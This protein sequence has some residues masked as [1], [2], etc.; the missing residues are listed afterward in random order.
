M[1]K[2]LK[3]DFHKKNLEKSLKN[4]ALLEKQSVL[5]FFRKGPN[6]SVKDLLINDLLDN[7]NF[8]L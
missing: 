4:K 2:S 1:E 8:I 7:K 3:I 6:N 5:L